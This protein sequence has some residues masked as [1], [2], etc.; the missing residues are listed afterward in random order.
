A[1]DGHVT[2]LDAAITALLTSATDRA[3][4]LVAIT[5]LGQLSTP[6][7]RAGVAGQVT[8]HDA[9]LKAA[10]VRTLASMRAFEEIEKLL[11]DEAADAELKIS[12]VKTIGQF[13]DGCLFLLTLIDDAKIK[14]GL[15]D[16][17]IRLGS[18]H[19]DINVRQLY[20]KYTPADSQPATIAQLDPKR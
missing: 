19:A 5:A 3:T 20:A 17:A 12:A 15:R 14:G 18:H 4:R 1:G 11:V 7:A 16:Q 6:A 9:S 10:A 13:A 2:S 8:S